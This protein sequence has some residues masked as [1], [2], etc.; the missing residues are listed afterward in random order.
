[1]LFSPDNKVMQLCAK[2][3]E[4]EGTGDFNVARTFYLEAWQLALSATEQFTV[5]HY[6]ARNVSV[7]ESL[8]WNKL[9]LE[10]AKC[11]NKEEVKSVFPSLYLNLGKS[12]EDIGDQINAGKYYN[13]A[14]QHIPFLDEDGYSKMIKSGVEAALIRISCCE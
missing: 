9:A 12:Y 13:Y 7:E 6:L 11:V 4:T 10:Y 5:A 3:I 1:M 8:Y 2:G 14:A